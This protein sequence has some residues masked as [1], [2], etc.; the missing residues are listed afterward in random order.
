MVFRIIPTLSLL[1]ALATS[2][3]AQEKVQITGTS[4]WINVTENLE[5]DP[6]SAMIAND[7]MGISFIDMAG[8]NYS[9]QKS[10]FDNAEAQYASEGIIVKELR[11]GKIANYDAILISLET[12]PSI[13]Q[14]FFG[15]E[16]F[17][18]FANVAAVDPQQEISITDVQA[19]LR[20]VEFRVEEG[21]SD[22]EKHA[23][24][25]LK[26]PL[27]QWRFDAYIASSFSFEHQEYDDIIMIVQLPP[28]TLSLSSP[29]ALTQE[30]ISKF[31]GEFS[32][33]K[34]E[35]AEKWSVHDIEGYRTILDLTEEGSAHLEL[36]YIYVFGT[37]QSTFIFQGLGAKKD[38]ETIKRIEA[39]LGNLSFG[40]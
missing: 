35:K 33:M 11:E 12:E 40:E 31:S 4:L 1:L 20:Q 14:A 13:V 10:D 17:C 15:N 7:L 29:E 32:K 9:E 24:F 27:D 26:Q 34:T 39:F 36:I 30:F 6:N 37:A 19:L 18:A 5:I 8:A 25:K 28:E 38:A 16:T 2:L 21:V 23:N 3:C 22:L